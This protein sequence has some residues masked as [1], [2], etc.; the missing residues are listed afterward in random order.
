M[1]A[2]LRDAEV[3]VKVVAVDGPGGAGKSSVS[4]ALAARLGWSHLDT[5][6]FYRAATLAVLRAGIDPENA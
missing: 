3:P 1:A 2:L 6:A 4:R 5:G